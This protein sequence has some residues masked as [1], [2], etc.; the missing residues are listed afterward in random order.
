MLIRVIS[1]CFFLF[2]FREG[3]SQTIFSENFES[4]SLP[5]GWSQ[6]SNA[7]D[8]GWKFG[9]ANKLQSQYWKIPSHSAIAAT[10]DDQCN[11]DKIEDKLTTPT[12]NL[13]G[14]SSPVLLFD[15][16]FNEG[17]YQGITEV[18]TVEI[19]TD[20]GASFT[21]A[22]TLLGNEIW[23]RN[24]IDL[25]NYADSIIQIG[26]TY[27]DSGGWSFGFAIDNVLIYDAVAL[28]LSVTEFDLPDYLLLSD[29]LLIEGEIT[30]FGTDT[31][32]SFNIN[33]LVNDSLALVDSISANVLPFGNYRFS[34]SEYFN[35]PADGTYEIKVWADYLNEN[36]DENKANDTLLY[37][38]HVVTQSA[39]RRPLVEEFSSSSCVPCANT[40]IS[41]NNLFESYFA[42]A[43][44][45]SISVIRYQMNLPDSTDPAYI[46]ENALRYG[47]YDSPAM[48]HAF[49]D[50]NFFKNSSGL[51][52]ASTIDAAMDEISVI[53]LSISYSLNGNNIGVIST[54][55][56][57]ADIPSQ[58]LKWH[59][60][61]TE[62]SIAHSQATNGDTVFY[63]I[64]R[65]M[66]L[67]EAGY[68][69]GP[70]TEGNPESV[71]L[72]E[73]LTTDTSVAGYLFTDISNISVI[74]FLQ[75]SATKEIYQSAVARWP[76]GTEE[77][78]AQGS[79][80]EVFPNPSHGVFK[81]RNHPVKWEGSEVEIYNILGEK[82][83]SSW[84][85]GRSSVLDISE[86]PNGIYFLKIT[87]SQLI[88]K[89][90]ISR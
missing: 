11:C 22:A 65:K 40:S 10:N 69:I 74:S 8:G 81:F 73:I 4:G 54:I 63:H 56:P 13:T 36:L 85:S 60:I 19:S 83:Y 6:Q 80:L 18:A 43:E 82:I 87:N 58:N 14:A 24:F 23:S 39:Q 48:P 76:T 33:C 31:I 32:S 52:S 57:L 9:K 44:G 12:I 15:V 42:N 70:L 64:V 79:E 77:I 88:Q 59:V 20:S 28:D 50:G 67:G 7:T 29:S 41:T 53:D 21:S 71:V 72:N 34:F 55:T 26:F 30:N 27:S 89:L 45:G 1:V 86:Q 3:A 37:T 66:L 35:P 68:S 2:S 61:I 75:D 38:I 84:L 62:D 46:S 25:S 5:P 16:F 90:I 47:F 17:T 51:L 49:I 78:I